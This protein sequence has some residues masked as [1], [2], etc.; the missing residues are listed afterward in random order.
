MQELNIAQLSKGIW[1]GGETEE[2]GWGQ[3]VPKTGPGRRKA[4]GEGTVKSRQG[5]KEPPGVASHSWKSGRKRA[6]QSCRG[7]IPKK[8]RTVEGVGESRA[9]TT[10][11]GERNRCVNKR[12][13]TSVDWDWYTYS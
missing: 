13:I 7:G 3:K 2:C 11:K 9:S 6:Y 1:G 8:N 10:S 5:N 4:D 12:G